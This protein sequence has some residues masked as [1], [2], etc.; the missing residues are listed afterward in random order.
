MMRWR[1]ELG[2]GGILALVAVALAGCVAP[3]EPS[4]SLDETGEELTIVPSGSGSSED[5]SD[6]G[7]SD[8]PPSAPV[9][10]DVMPD[11]L[12]WRDELTRASNTTLR[13]PG[14]QQGPDPLPWDPGTQSSP[15]TG[16]SHDKE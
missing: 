7:A 16:S 6:D 2:L 11:P 3:L 14:A 15:G 8:D 9:A 12:P 4:E 10:G 5:S 1:M 13:D